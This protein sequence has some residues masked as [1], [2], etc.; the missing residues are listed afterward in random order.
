MK[1]VKGPLVWAD[2]ENETA[3][4][5]SLHCYYSRERGPRWSRHMG[6]SA[7]CNKKLGISDDGDGFLPVDK[8]IP[9]TL[10]RAT[11]CKRCLK[12]YDKQLVLK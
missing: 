12:I 9:S 4:T 10:N 8:I 7:L 3:T 1:E 2:V 6:N 11:A 5:S